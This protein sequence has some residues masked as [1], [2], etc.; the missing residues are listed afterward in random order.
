MSGTERTAPV[1]Y[2]VPT[3][4][5][6]LGRSGEP[7]APVRPAPVGRSGQATAAPD[8]DGLVA[9]GAGLCRQCRAD[10]H[11]HAPCDGTGRDGGR[12]CQ[13]CRFGRVCPRCGRYWTSP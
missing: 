6:E 8:F 4:T 7:A 2:S 1:L 9:V 11:D 12:L 10:L 13:G 3:P 5:R